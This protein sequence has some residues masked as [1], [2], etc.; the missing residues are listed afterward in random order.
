[1]TSLA[2]SSSS[3]TSVSTTSKSTNNCDLDEKVD[4]VGTALITNLS[5][6]ADS[7]DSFIGEQPLQILPTTKPLQPFI[8]PESKGKKSDSTSLVPNKN[9][10]TR[11]G[12]GSS[13]AEDDDDEFQCI[14][15]T[16][17]PL[18]WEEAPE[19]KVA[20]ILSYS[21]SGDTESVLYLLR[22]ADKEVKS[23]LKRNSQFR[24]FVRDSTELQAFF[25]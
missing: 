8:N 21:N 15:G 3:S 19:D 16:S 12:R 23:K 10:P 20:R 22:Y 7:M 14:S 1:M 5:W 2:I 17:S 24:K 6:S 11:Q 9:K 13:V 18:G 25:F 4:V